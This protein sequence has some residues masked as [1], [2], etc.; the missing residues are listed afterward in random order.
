MGTR[1]LTMVISNGE[2][3]VAQYGQWDGYPRGQ[4]ATALSFLRSCD[5]KKFKQKVD[6]LSFLSDSECQKL[7]D[8]GNWSEKYPWLTRDIGAEILTAIYEG[9]LRVRSGVADKK[10]ISVSVSKLVNSEGFANDS[11]FCEWGYVIDLDRNTF[12]V[13]KGFNKKPLGKK[14]RFKFLEEPIS[15]KV[16][17]EKQNK[18]LENPRDKYFPIRMVKSYSL[19][20]LPDMGGF[21]ADFK[22]E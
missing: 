2:T 6:S 17:T 16:I 3:K 21:F 12:E 1:N 11:L 7:D 22:E 20:D 14:Q 4:G 5:L 18:K 13:Y 9:K 8:E 10:E 15:R 19:D